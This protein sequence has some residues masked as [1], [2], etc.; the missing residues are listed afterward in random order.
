MTA[1]RP[2]KRYLLRT[3]M[4]IKRAPLHRIDHRWYE[5]LH[6]YRW[7]MQ[8]ALTGAIIAGAVPL[9]AADDVT[10]AHVTAASL[11]VSGN[12]TLAGGLAVGGNAAVDGNISAGASVTT[13]LLIASGFRYQMNDPVANVPLA[14]WWL[15]GNGNGP[16]V[17]FLQHGISEGPA[18]R[19]G[20]LGWMDNGSNKTEFLTWNET[21][22]VGIGTDTTAAAWPKLDVAGNGRFG[23][24]H[25][26]KTI[27]LQSVGSPTY[28]SATYLINDAGIAQGA[29][30][31][32]ST[33]NLVGAAGIGTAYKSN[34]AIQYSTNTQGYGGNPSDP[35]VTN[36]SGLTYATALTVDGNGGKVGVGTTSPGEKLEVAGNIKAAGLIIGD[37]AFDPSEYIKVN[38]SGV[39]TLGSLTATGGTITGGNAGL[40]IL[41]G[42]QNQN[43]KLTPTGTGATIFDGRVMTENVVGA[44][45][46]VTA[47]GEIFSG[48]TAGGSQIYKALRIGQSRVQTYDDALISKNFGPF[49]GADTY[50][51]YENAAYGGME[52]R[53]GQSGSQDIYFY[54][55]GVPQAPSTAFVPEPQMVI[56]GVSGNM[57]IGT[58]AT[59]YRLSVYAGGDDDGI[60]ISH[61]SRNAFTITGTQGRAF[62]FSAD[63]GGAN[64]GAIEYASGNRGIVLDSS[65]SPERLEF[66]SNDKKTVV[67]SD[68]KVGIGTPAGNIN[69]VLTVAGNISFGP[70]M[71]DSENTPRMDVEGGKATA[72]RDQIGN[73]ALFV[74]GGNIGIAGKLYL[75]AD[76]AG[77]SID[78]AGS[79]IDS[80]SGAGLRYVAQGGEHRFDNGNV[81]IMKDLTVGG[82]LNV[83]DATV[84]QSTLSV[85]GSLTANAGATINN[86]P[87]VATR[88]VVTSS[89]SGY[90]GSN[91]LIL[92]AGGTGDQTITLAP[93]GTGSVQ[94][95]GNVLTD[96]GY[97]FGVAVDGT[98]TI[99]GG[100]KK[101][102][103]GI[104]FYG[105]AGT[106]KALRIGSAYAGTLPADGDAIF[107]GK[108]GIGTGAQTPVGKLQV[109]GGVAVG[110]SGNSALQPPGA[111][112]EIV[113]RPI[114]GT[115]A[116]VYFQHDGTDSVFLKS[117]GTSRFTM[118]GAN[119]GEFV[120]VDNRNGNVGIGTATT[121]P[122]AKLEVVGDGKFSAN[123]N[124]DGTLRVGAGA[125]ITTIN[126]GT[127]TTAGAVTAATVNASQGM[128]VT[129]GGV[130]V[131]SG[132]VTLGVGGNVNLNAGRL[133]GVATAASS[134]LT[135]AA[136]VTYVNE[137][138]PFAWNRDA[139]L[140]SLR[141]GD[142]KLGL[143]TSSPQFRLDVADASGIRLDNLGMGNGLLLRRN[144]G[145]TWK[146]GIGVSAAADT[147]T[148]ASDT[149]GGGRLA[150]T[151]AGRVGVGTTSPQAT[152][153]VI[154][155]PL[156]Q[157]GSDDEVSGAQVTIEAPQ[158]EKYHYILFR[159]AG[160]TGARNAGFASIGFRDNG[161]DGGSLWLGTK[162]DDS[163][164]AGVPQP[165]MFIDST[166]NV[167]IGTDKT[168]DAK[169]SVDGVVRAREV[170]VNSEVWAD[171]VFDEKYRNAPLSEV[172]QHIKEHKHLPGV[173]S[174]K[175]V[176]ERGV[177]IGQM[178]AVLLAKVE[179]LTLH[180]IEQ[181]KRIKRL[182]AENL[183]LRSSR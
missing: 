116:G 147:F 123:L 88:G 102:N 84:L 96:G 126:Q 61:A 136:N 38:G 152:L 78:T 118:L 114:S 3:A 56:K 165:R 163:G 170:L 73:R 127:I 97:L 14:P 22:N 11:S 104:D 181:E 59:P 68:G 154:A 151:A 76:T 133:T 132:N 9:H 107:S 17:M 101:L 47:A 150:I 20:S 93:T 4:N 65:A 63:K 58:T 98:S 117:N 36:L 1:L 7:K 15:T 171:Y 106:F 179:E 121:A 67:V 41:A 52:F 131:V 34:L 155:P 33:Q 37:Q 161:S 162:A 51:T 95:L 23:V 134:D 178:Q 119:G 81:S 12:T 72:L 53:S 176:T 175:E 57:G 105:E 75:R 45:N 113:V 28:G 50:Q 64:V 146:L 44:N 111:G 25:Q 166:G 149:A 46:M 80:P 83:T 183:A 70:V 100:I 31:L 137:R 94:L 6:S 142:D 74:Q 27:S 90:S 79:Y 182:E 10:F 103:N 138:T 129:T 158:N 168:Q 69:Q 85:G 153:H 112:S 48:N 173:P 167:G 156:P 66:W 30:R 122:S 32:L 169:L 92:A 13:P 110:G 2:L 139:H 177:N 128:T 141:D 60:N 180:M 135:S 77:S 148:V 24:P 125:D 143:G 54:A 144:S 26:G 159:N 39:V 29:I 124:V 42:G 87:L 109:V 35:S 140:I 18:F 43:I 89:M 55:S 21:G 120:T 19:R 172:E 145:Q 5:R 62:A 160:S 157:S 108:I 71:Y 82:T 91:G 40:A 49:L 16:A 164:Q 8:W 86:S 99:S 115:T 174:A 130:T